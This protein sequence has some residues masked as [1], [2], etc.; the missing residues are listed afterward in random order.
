MKIVPRRT[1]ALT[2]DPIA[3]RPAA[4]ELPAEAVLALS[5]ASVRQRTLD[6][7]APSNDRAVAANEVLTLLSRLTPRLRSVPVRKRGRTLV[8]LTTRGDSL[9]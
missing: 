9:A 8:L 7:S 1:G 5:V 4:Y 3:E 2:D 6:L